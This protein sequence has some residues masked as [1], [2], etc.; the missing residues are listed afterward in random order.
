MNVVM[1]RKIPILDESDNKLFKETLYDLSTPYGYGGFLIEGNIDEES[2]NEL[3][4]EYTKYCVSNSIISEFCRFHPVNDNIKNIGQMYESV[5]LG[6]TV[7]IPSK[8]KEIVWNT[9]YGK[10]RN[11][12]RKAKKMGVEINWGRSSELLKEFIPMYNAT[13]NRD[14]ATDYYYFDEKFYNSLLND[15]KYNHLIFYAIFEN[16]IISMAI[17]IFANNQAHYHLSASNRDYQHLSATNLLLY[18]AAC[19]ASKNGYSS[20][21]L[22]GGLGSKEDSLFKFKSAFNKKSDTVFSIGKK[23]FDTEKYNKLVEVV[24]KQNPDTKNSNYFPEYRVGVSK[25]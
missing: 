10:N 4:R 17:I 21:H 12:I 22:G 2:I 25:F 6:R 1:K 15:L 3:D 19:W 20:F 14:S 24:N 8:S 9:L 18:E 5:T 7:T 16:Q 11:V 23:I 13:M